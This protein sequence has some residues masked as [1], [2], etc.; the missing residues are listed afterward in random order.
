M[1]NSPVF[2]VYVLCIIGYLLY[3]II[4]KRADIMAT[5]K[6]GSK[7]EDVKVLQR[8]LNLTDDG[9][10]GKMTDAAVKKWQKEHGL[11]V[12]GIVGPKTWESLGIKDD[13]KST[14]S[15][16]VDPEVVYLPLNVHITKSVN[17]PIKYLAIHYTAGSS[18]GKGRARAIKHVFEERKASADFAVDDF[19]MVQFNPDIKNYYCWAVGDKKTTAE[20][21]A[22]VTD[23]RNTNTI[24]IEVCSTLKKGTSLAKANHTGWSYTDAALNNAVKLAKI[25]MK[26]FNIPVERV[27]RHYDISG[28]LCPGLVGYNNG[29]LYNEDG[30][31]TGKKNNSDKWK[32]FKE[33]LTK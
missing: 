15:K 33:R 12:D 2:F 21:G 7:G 11:T 8:K 27:V 25:L 3:I 20:G 23:G 22:S 5:I 32:E 19:E 1:C 10:F 9:I 18:S 16:C 28:K 24:S 6:L 17:R 4:Y 30:T 29:P 31:K 14:N 13:N 26:K